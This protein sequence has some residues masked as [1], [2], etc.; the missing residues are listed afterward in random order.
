MSA[1]FPS[2]I[3]GFEREQGTKKEKER[4]TG[5]TNIEI[6]RERKETYI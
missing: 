6:N 3:F 5:K 2:N 1:H 4:E